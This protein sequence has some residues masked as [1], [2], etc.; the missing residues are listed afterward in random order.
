MEDTVLDFK[1]H[2]KATILK[3][4]ALVERETN[5][6]SIEAY[7]ENQKTDPHICGPLIFD[8]GMKTIQRK[9]TLTL[10]LLHV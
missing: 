5:N 6:S 9:T 4:V 7:I 10:T 2:F 8:K 1:I 3:T